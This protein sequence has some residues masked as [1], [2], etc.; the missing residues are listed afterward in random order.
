MDHHGAGPWLNRLHAPVGF[1]ISA[2]AGKHFSE[3]DL[4]KRI[5]DHRALGLDL[6]SILERHTRGPTVSPV[7]APDLGIEMDLAAKFLQVPG[8]R[9]DHHIGA[10]LAERHA[11]TLVCHGF[12]IGKERAARDIG[13]EIEMKSPG[14]ERRLDLVGLEALIKERARR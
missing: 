11:E 3:D 5:G 13:R 8:Q 6:S 12:E 9:L 10:A 4:R 1:R 7:D 14:G 2:A